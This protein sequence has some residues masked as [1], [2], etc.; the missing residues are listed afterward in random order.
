M[1]SPSQPKLPTIK[2]NS[3]KLEDGST[4]SFKSTSDSV[5]AA[6]ETYGCF[7]IDYE[8]MSSQLHEAMYG[9]SEELF[10]LPMETKRNHTSKL[11][12][13]GYGGNFSV[14]PLFE[15]FGIEHYRT[16]LESMGKFTGLFWP[17]G[18]QYFCETLHSYCN[19][20]SD[21]YW[22]VMKMVTSSYRLER[23]YSPLETASFY[24]TRLMRYHAPGEG[25]SNVGILPHRD[26]SFLSVIGTNEVR[27]LEIET[28]DGDWIHFEP[29]PTKFIVVV[30]EALMA[31]SNGRIY[32]PLHKVVVR[33]I[34]EKYSI[35]TFSFVRGIV[36]VPQELVNDKNP[37][38]FKPFNHL[39]FLEYC[40]EGGSKMSGAIQSYYEESNRIES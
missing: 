14:M 24:M 4:D 40:R 27:G 25:K 26:K 5:L 13:F 35:G 30:G 2:F 23:H 8:G 19:L 10:R 3:E 31:W 12:G 1:D 15:Y 33:G 32:C 17:D 22:T 21:L 38:K 18:N 7:V 36:E 28:R 20:L 29:A 9:L 11:A 6:M 16:D 37:L 34:K 39:D